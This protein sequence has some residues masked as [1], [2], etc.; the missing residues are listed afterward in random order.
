MN[1]LDALVLAPTPDGFDFRLEGELLGSCALE[2]TRLTHF[3][4]ASDQRRRGVG[5]RAMDML[6]ATLPE[7]ARI[8]IELPAGDQGAEEF[9]REVGFGVKAVVFDR[10]AK[11]SEEPVTLFRPVGQKELD[12]IEASGMRAF[13][14]RLP[15][16]PIFYPI[17][18]ID[19]ARLI[20]AD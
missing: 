5:R 1:P 4:V 6:L 14:P 8:E 7:G 15:D 2:G 12:L 10:R 20:A 3:V 18:T 13:P 19:Y 11:P 9:A 17:T 16:Q